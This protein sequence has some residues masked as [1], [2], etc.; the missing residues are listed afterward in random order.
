MNDDNDLLN[1]VNLALK[2][3]SE[4]INEKFNEIEA[5]LKNINEKIETIEKKKT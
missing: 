2:T 1:K 4:G 3:F 5:K